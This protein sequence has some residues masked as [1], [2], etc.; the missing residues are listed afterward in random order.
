MTETYE[1]KF[2]R[3][4]KEKTKSIDEVYRGTLPPKLIKDMKM[5]ELYT[6]VI[7]WGEKSVQGL[8]CGIYGCNS[9]PN[10][11]CPICHCGY[12]SE[13]LKMHFH[14]AENDGIHLEE[15]E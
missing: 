2:N 12:C 3:I 10:T 4:V 15:I 5:G 11:P 6:E 13:H 1:E 14:S 9:E 8:L 7:K